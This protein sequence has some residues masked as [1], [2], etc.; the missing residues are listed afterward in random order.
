MKHAVTRALTETVSHVCD[1]MTA[2]LQAQAKQEGVPAAEAETLF[3]RF[4][5][6]GWVADSQDE[7]YLSR[8]Y[9]EPGRPP[10]GLL[11]R[12]GN[13]LPERAGDRLDELVNQRLRQDGTL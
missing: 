4:H 12:F 13:R 11:R 2:A 5:E 6:G 7:T 1:E 9:G 8:E 3:V 10:L